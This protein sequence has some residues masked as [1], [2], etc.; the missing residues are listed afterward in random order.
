MGV[1]ELV[2]QALAVGVAVADGL[3][4]AVLL[5]GAGVDA[6]LP[7]QHALLGLAELLPP[8]AQ[9]TLHLA[10]DAMDLFLRLE[11][12]LLD[13]GLSLT[14]RVPE[15]LLGLTFGARQLARGEVAADEVPHRD[16]DHQANNHIDRNHHPIPSQVARHEK[17]PGNAPG[18]CHARTCTTI[19]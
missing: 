8:L 9:L 3:L 11:A 5:G 7:L 6:L 17:G 16:A 15:E 14:A 2:R 1:V 18:R 10:T 4:P 13:D 19:R 12:S